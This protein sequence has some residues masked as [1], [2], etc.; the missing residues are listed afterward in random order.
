MIFESFYKSL[1]CLSVVVIIFQSVFHSEKYVNNVF[2]LF[3]NHFWDQH[4]K[5]IWKHQKHINLKQ[6][7]FNF[8]KNT[9]QTHCQTPEKPLPWHFLIQPWIL[10]RLL[11]VICTIYLFWMSIYISR[12]SLSYISSHGSH[13]YAN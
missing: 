4:I 11:L 8:F 12:L 7:K 1:T 6:K 2:L 10:P 13:S 5:M 9:F 3:K